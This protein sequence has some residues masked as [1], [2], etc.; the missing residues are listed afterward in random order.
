MR[1]LRQVF[2]AVTCLLLGAGLASAQNCCA[3]S[4]AQQGVLGE[5]VTLPKTLEIG[6]HYEYLRN[7]GMYE[8]SESVDDAANT[9]T[10]WHRATL[11][12]SYGISPRLGV[13][14]IVP[15]VWKKKTRELQYSGLISPASDGI[16]DMTLMARY[17]L[18]PRS[19]VNYRE[20]TVGA[21]IKIPTGATDTEY[22][23]LG[24]PEELQPGTG[25]WDFTG[26]ASFYQGYETV[27]FW[28]SASYTLTS[29]YEDYRFGNQ[30]SYL[31]TASYHFSERMDFS[32]ALSGIVRGK[33]TKDG[34]GVDDT[35]REQLWIVPG[36]T[37]VVVPEA[38]RLQVFFEYPI[39]QHG[40]E[41][42]LGSD[43]NF[44]VSAVYTLP[45]SKADEE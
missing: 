29:E 10:R 22:N 16:G 7:E 14:A 5:T 11:A 13:S 40:N 6:L 25:S 31:L 23:G 15:F 17:S 4:V 24:L 34:D 36:V 19:F 39:Y 9:M 45:F 12:L 27:D 8:G 1:T 18:F 37:A 28:M 20:V 2:L 42:Q 43:Y 41:I 26:S 32:A 44:R 30:F 38:L 35:G 33:D 3:P 21:G